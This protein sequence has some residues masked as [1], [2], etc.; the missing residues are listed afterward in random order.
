GGDGLLGASMEPSPERDGEAR[1][2]ARIARMAK[3]QWSRR[4][5]ATESKFD[6][7]GRQ[8][9]ESLQWSRRLNATERQHEPLGVRERVEASMEPSPE[10][11]GEPPGAHGHCRLRDASMEPSPERDGECFCQMRAT[12][13]SAELQWSRRLNATESK[14]IGVLGAQNLML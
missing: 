7:Q 3:L 8:K 14:E 10:R 13:C 5:N 2:V 11:D 4:L 9:V 12:R 6:A 1:A